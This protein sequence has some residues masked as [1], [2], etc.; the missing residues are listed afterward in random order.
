MDNL[1]LI[2]KFKLAG[3][4]HL[5]VKS[6]ARIRVDGRGGLMFYDTQSRAVETIKLRTLRSFSIQQIS[7]AREQL[8]ALAMA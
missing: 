4:G 1:N 8:A 7:P 5:Y 6:A 3:D 2:L